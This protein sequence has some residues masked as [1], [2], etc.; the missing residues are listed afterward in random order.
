MKR[1]CIRNC[2]IKRRGYTD[3]CLCFESGQF[4]D[5]YMVGL[6]IISIEGPRGIFPFYYRGGWGEDTSLIY[7]DYFISLEEYRDVKLGELGI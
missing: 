6:T 3:E 7:E 2:Y 1:V 5:V 4:Y